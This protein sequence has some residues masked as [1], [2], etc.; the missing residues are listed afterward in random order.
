MNVIC[1]SSKGNYFDLQI[2]C[3][4]EQIRAQRFP[5]LVTDRIHPIFRAE[6]TMH[7]VDGV[8]M[9]HLCRPFGACFWCDAFPPLTRWANKYHRSA[10]VNNRSFLAV[11]G[12]SNFCLLSP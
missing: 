3:Y 7:D 2:A 9:R 5:Q 6:N 4:P 8:G 1:G 11:T 12:L 10:A